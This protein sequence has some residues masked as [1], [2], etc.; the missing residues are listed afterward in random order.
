MPAP[1]DLHNFK[2]KNAIPISVHGNVLYDY[3]YRSK[4]NSL[5][6]Q[7]DL[8]QHTEKFDI[9]ILNKE[10]YPLK[11]AFKLR[12]SNSPYSRQFADVNMH[13]DPFSYRKSFKQNLINKL[14]KVLSNTKDIRFLEASIFDKEEQLFKLKSW[15]KSPAILQKIIEERELIY[16]QKTQIKTSQPTLQ[17]PAVEVIPSFHK[18]RNAFNSA[19]AH[20]QKIDSS[21]ISLAEL[22][23]KKE[24]EIEQLSQNIKSLTQRL[25]LLKR[26]SRKNITVANQQIFFA[27]AGV[28]FKNKKL[29]TVRVSKFPSIT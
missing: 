10:K 6:N 12:Q 21:T 1:N 24:N 19:S 23:A 14:S 25:E 18:N 13:F 4:I 28:R 29:L 9:D 8:Q 7:N 15:C 17:L 26:V 5:F 3:Y 20:I 11:L 27:F 22:F 2:T 16:N